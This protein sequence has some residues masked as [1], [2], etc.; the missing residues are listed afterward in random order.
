[1]RI[2][3]DKNECIE[4]L[5]QNY[6]GRIAYISSGFPHI[7]PLTYYYDPETKTIISY[8]SEGHKIKEMRKNIAVCLAVDEITSVSNWKSVL[9]HGTFEE[10]SRIDAKHM[11]RKFAEGVKNIIHTKTGGNP[12]HISE[13]SA[14]NDA[15]DSPIVF[16]I[17]ISELTGKSRSATH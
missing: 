5:E 15:K 17:N 2:N 7:V 14:K 11:L 1:M 6:I 4:L 13:F 3:L 12:K 8:S 16:R 10:L 9:A